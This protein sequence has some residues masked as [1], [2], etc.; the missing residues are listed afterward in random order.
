MPLDLKFT[1]SPTIH[2]TDYVKGDVVKIENSRSNV[3]ALV[4][5]I[6]MSCFASASAAAQTREIKPSPSTERNKMTEPKGFYCNTKG[7][8]KD[9]RTRYNELTTKVVHTRA[10]T[11]QLTDGYA[12]RLQPGGGSIADLAEWVSYERKCCPF[13][14]FEIELEGNGGPLWLKLRGAEGVKPFIRAEFHVE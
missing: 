7:L 12:F 5:S 4:L 8:S 9:E 1:L 11:K 13:F 2:F 3:A 6:T 10:E 14:T